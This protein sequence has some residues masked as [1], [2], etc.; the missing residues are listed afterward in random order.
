MREA[1]L[2]VVKSDLWKEWQS[3]SQSCWWERAD[4]EALKDARLKS[5]VKQAYSN[6]PY[7][8][9]LFDSSGL[10]PADIQSSADLPKIP[11]LTRREVR[12]HLSRMLARNVRSRDRKLDSTGGSTGEP[13]RFY[14]DLSTPATMAATYRGFEWYGYEFGSQLGYLWGAPRDL[15]LQN[16]IAGRLKSWVANTFQMDAFNLTNETMQRYVDL[17]RSSPSFGIVG[18]ASALVQISRFM[19]DSGQ[20][21]IG[22]KF[23]SSQAETLYP[24]YRQTIEAAFG[25]P[26]YDFYGSREIGAIA[27]ECPEGR[28]RHISEE[29]V[30]VEIVDEGGTPVPRGQ[31]GRVLLTSLRN[32]AMPLLRYEIGDMATNTLDEKCQCGRSLQVLEG[33]VGRVGSVIVADDGRRIASEYFPHFF[34]EVP[35]VR[36]FQVVQ[37]QDGFVTISVA[38]LDH[39]LERERANLETRLRLELGPQLRLALVLC[40]S[41]DPRASGKRD[42]VQS[43]LSVL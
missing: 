3:L 23:V 8:Q 10:K 12:T 37:R 5:L 40:E 11:L 24:S 2:R 42:F 15:R 16:S 32:Y 14:R 27:I 41:I 19:L 1:L 35:W 6:V 29:N 7:Y 22:P 33:L 20:K 9:D 25:C 31:S 4:I 26:V 34:K 38:A 39:V 18:Y 28:R 30:I 43:A 36:S 21:V 13:V 17:L